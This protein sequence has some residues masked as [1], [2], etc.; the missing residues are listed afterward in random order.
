MN[1]DGN[2]NYNAWQPAVVYNVLD[3]EY[4]VVWQGDDGV[5]G[6]VNDEME[7]YG[8]RLNA[9]TGA[10]VLPNDFRISEMGGDGNNSYNA[11]NP[12]VAYDSTNQRYLVVWSGDTN[13]SAVG[14]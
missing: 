4:L 14:G 2:T 1:V 8:Q 5:G 10:E 11:H 7:I 12:S 13:T 6:L 9:S 3:N